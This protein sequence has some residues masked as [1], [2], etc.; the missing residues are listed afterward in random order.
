[1]LDVVVPSICS[2]TRRTVHWYKRLREVHFY[3]TL[4]NFVQFVFG[5]SY[6]PQ[7]LCA[8][9]MALV[10]GSHF[11]HMPRQLPA[12]DCERMVLDVRTLSRA[13]TM[14]GTC[15]ETVSNWETTV[16]A[17]MQGMVYEAF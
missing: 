15:S 16:T 14:Y 2:E 11:G 17:T 5:H 3:D 1:M 10:H 13:V 8:A 6:D 7:C 4:S 9:K 12:H